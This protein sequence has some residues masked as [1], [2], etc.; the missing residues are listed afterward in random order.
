MIFNFEA[1]AD[2]TVCVTTRGSTFDTSL[3]VRGGDCAGDVE[4]ACAD[5]SDDGIEIPGIVGLRSAV[6]FN[7]VAGENY[8]IFVDAFSDFSRG[9][10]VLS[11]SAGPC[12][13]NDP[14][15]CIDDEDCP[16]S[17]VCRDNA[18]EFF[19]EDDNACGPRQICQ[20]GA[21]ADVECRIDDQCIGGVC[22]DDNTCAQC[23]VAEDCAGI[24]CAGG[25]C[26]CAGNAC[27]QCA[28]DADCVDSV[29]AL[30]GENAN[31]CVACLETAQC[32][33]G[34]IC[35]GNACI[36]QPDGGGICEAPIAYALGE[37]LTGTLTDGLLRDNASGC[38]AAGAGPEKVHSF[39][40]AED[41]EVCLQTR[42]SAL[43]DPVL[44]V[45]DT[46]CTGP[47]ANEVA[48]NDNNRFAGGFQSALSFNAVAGVEYFIMVDSFFLE[49]AEGA[50]TYVLTSR[51]G[52]CEGDPIPVC[53]EDADCVAGAC[54][55]GECGDGPPPPPPF[56]H[57]P[58][59]PRPQQ[60]AQPPPQSQFQLGGG[61]PP[62][63]PHRY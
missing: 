22:L 11:S 62:P 28:A 31:T 26:V 63:P 25:A 42:G 1:A 58:P 40:V 60:Y 56:G 50:D 46:A 59:P 18:C 47:A 55:D 10:Y 57:A 27:V 36:A 9:D 29:C 20:E 15:I 12:L 24:D 7:V 23:G 16:F 38:A 54:V 39:T 32:D 41:T 51:V 5:D 21:C 53:A 35:F 4:L 19:C 8:F 44:Y 17:N 33:D 14:P 49:V 2:G 6:E 48:C 43:L 61:G 52:P 30:D 3:Y 37:V 34:E 13:A 45:R